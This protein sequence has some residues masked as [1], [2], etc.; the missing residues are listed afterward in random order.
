MAAALAVTVV[1]GLDYLVEAYRLTR[2]AR[3]S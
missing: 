2:R 3:S 1:T